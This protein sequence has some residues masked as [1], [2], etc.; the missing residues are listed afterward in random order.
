VGRTSSQIQSILS[1][2][3]TT[4]TTTTTEK[5]LPYITPTIQKNKKTKML[6]RLFHLGTST[7]NKKNKALLD[8]QQ[9]ATGAATTDN[10]AR[11]STGTDIN[12]NNNNNNTKNNYKTESA[13]SSQTALNNNNNNNNVIIQKLSNQSF[14]STTTN[15]PDKKFSKESFNTAIDKKASSQSLPST[16]G[17]LPSKKT[18][19]PT[20]EDKLVLN[21][22][23]NSLES[24]PL[25]SSSNG[26]RDRTAS[27]E[28]RHSESRAALHLTRLLDNNK[29]WAKTM[30]QTDPMFF[31][32]LTEQQ[33]PEFLWIGCSDSRVPANQ[34]TGMAPG[35]VFVHRNVANLVHPDDPNLL[36]VIQYAVNNLKV[37]HI[38]VCGHAGCGGVKASIEQSPLP[39]PLHTW[40]EPIRCICKEH[41]EFLSKMTDFE[42]KWKWVCEASVRKN[43]EILA[44]L[45]VIQGAWARGQQLALHGWSYSIQDGLLRDLCVTTELGFD[46]DDDG[47]LL[48]G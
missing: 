5:K 13:R 4:A 17:L 23:L 25:N 24:S 32:R 14:N 2:P 34:I 1:Y 30:V 7:R 11:D 37:K 44:Q 46:D 31:N 26:G 19:V 48:N 40:L 45:P 27:F 47:S 3:G 16:N 43:V 42:S 6:A 12:N 28:I 39:D 9:N 29:K 20:F 22:Q 36:S 21:T 41:S 38:I 35:E 10:G 33:A 8:Q 15:G 18:S